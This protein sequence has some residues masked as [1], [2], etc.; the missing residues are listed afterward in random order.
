MSM[1]VI[2]YLCLILVSGGTIIYFDKDPSSVQLFE[3]VCLAVMVCAAAA[4]VKI[5]VK[6]EREQK[7]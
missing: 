6:V 1:K 3:W 4:L 5:L 7:W 2:S